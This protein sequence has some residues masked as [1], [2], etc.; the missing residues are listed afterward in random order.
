MKG[1]QLLNV[2]W[3]VD[4]EIRLRVSDDEL[5]DDEDQVRSNQ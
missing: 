5:E 4:G 1:L 2:Y 3:R